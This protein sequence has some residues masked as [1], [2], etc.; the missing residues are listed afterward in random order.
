MRLD[1][2]AGAGLLLIEIA[3]GQLAIGG[4]RPCVEQ[5]FAAGHIGMTLG[6]QRFDDR[7]HLGDIV[8]GARFDG[9][10]QICPVARHRAVLVGR[11]LRHFRD[12]IIERQIGKIPERPRVDLVIDVGN[13]AGIGDVSLAID[14]PQ[15]PV[16]HVKD[17]HRSGIADMGKII[18][19]RTADIHAHVFR[20]DRGE[21]D[22]AASQCIVK[23]EGPR[24]WRSPDV[25]IPGWTGAFVIWDFARDEN[26][27][28][29]ACA[30]E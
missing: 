11:L 4:H 15:Q 30:S 28:A 2:D 27:R 19:R 5:H 8:C 7:D 26:G 22:L 10:R 21:I 14:M 20:V 16:E 18:D 13:V 1:S 24:P 25:M 29:S 3:L 12:G 17:D 9:R 23:L 6:D